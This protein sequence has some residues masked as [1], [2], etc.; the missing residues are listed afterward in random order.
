MRIKP[1]YLVSACLA[2]E[3][4]RYNGMSS[5]DREVIF[6]VDNGLAVPVCPEKLGGLPI[7]RPKVEI[8]KGDGK[9][10]LSSRSK[11]VNEKGE[12]VTSEMIK[13][14]RETLRI[15]KGYRIKAAYMKNKSPSCGCGKICRKGRIV[16]GDGVTAALLKDGDIEVIPK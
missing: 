3:R 4:C 13:G 16:K 7:P 10:V 14:A 6:L 9:D 8:E 2:G 12:D 1:E 5:A 15:A 11:V